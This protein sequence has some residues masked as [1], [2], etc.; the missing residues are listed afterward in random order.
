M[1]RNLICS[2]IFTFV[3]IMLA[4][5][6][7]ALA[8][9]AGAGQ[10]EELVVTARR[11]EESLQ[12][13]PISIVALTG[14]EME[15]R[16][17]QRVED[18]VTSTPNVMVSAGPSTAFNQFAMRG[19]PR[20]GFFV[21]DVWQQST[22]QVSQRSTL[23]LER[24]EVLRGPQ[25]TLYGRDTTGGAIRLYTKRPAE[26]FGVRAGATVGSY[27]RLDLSLFADLPISDTLK[28]KLS[29]S[30]Q[31]RDG[32]VDSIVVNRSTGDMDD[33]RIHG[34]L[35][36]TPNDRLEVRATAEDSQYKGT[37]A[38]VTL[39][40]WD[41]GAPGVDAGFIDPLGRSIFWVPNS[42]YYQLSGLRYDCKSHV[43]NCPGGEVG[44]LQTKSQYNEGPGIDIDLQNYNLKI[45]YQITDNISV[46][47][48]THYHEQ[49][50][51]SYNNFTAADLDYFSQ[52]NYIDREG[53]TQEFQFNGDHGRAHWMVGLYGWE[54]KTK[55]HFM[56]WALWEY[57]TG[58]L[59]FNA[60]RNTPEC[61]SWNPASGLAPC[62]Q[63]P[64]SQDRITSTR[65]RGN[66]IF[67]QFTYDITEALSVT[68]GARYHDQENSNWDEP[69][70]AAT[71]LRTNVPGRL[72]AG[73]LLASGPRTGERKNEFSQD[74][75]RFAATYNFDDDVMVFAGF[76]QGYNA[77]GISRVRIFDLDNN[78]ITFDFPFDPE[79][80]NNYEIG[81]RS[82]WLN[83]RL[84]VN[85]TAFFT[86]WEDIQLSGTVINPFTGLVLPTFLT[87]NAATAEAKGAEFEIT[88][89]PSENWL[90]NLNI[91]FLDTEYTGVA[92]GSELA[93]SDSFGQ[94][95]DLQY[96]LGGQWNGELSNGGAVIAR[97]DYNYTAGY[98]RTY[99][100]G[101]RST[102]YLGGEFEQPS[103]GLLN[104]RLSYTP[105]DGNWTIALF[106]TNLTD[107]RYTNG[108]FMSP[109][110]QVDDGTIG[111]PREY[112]LSINFDLG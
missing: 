62:I 11:R 50:S 93:T 61:R 110:L 82:D 30:S 80:I 43:M 54:E 86:E 64:P 17:I 72:P 3:V 73:D 4:P 13:V 51:W 63:V 79:Q 37:Q 29:V 70:S 66:A 10:L 77:G 81:F 44:D 89:L 67:G 104:A 32:F 95:P 38:N 16:S 46:S 74:T 90:F 25:G 101:D 27:A 53:W 23:E 102:T 41:P 47:S 87:T 99:V 69:F 97:V 34:D 24:F 57:V 8:Q 112:G 42:Q 52:G 59:D 6:P 40:I 105:P 18:I 5:Q 83:R 71:A 60:V 26:E 84:R 65:E 108:G 28:S 31:T 92:E 48:L 106:A 22:V 7:I 55:N 39:G 14:A 2:S 56:R 98:D 100:P 94:A 96:S 68:V 1:V 36:W 49:L 15:L 35:L 88:Y 58:E 33:K 76:S 21:D 107:E 12:E 19:I 111:R 109:L 9:Q 45:D 78:A 91:G 20:A 75:Y 103:F 85:G